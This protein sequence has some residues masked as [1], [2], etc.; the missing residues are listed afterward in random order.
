MQGRVVAFENFEDRHVPEWGPLLGL[1]ELRRRPYVC[2]GFVAMGRDPGEGILRRLDDLQ[3]GV[4]YGRSYFS[5]NVLEEP[6]PDY[7]FLYL[8]QDVLNA[9]LAGSI[10]P[11][12]IETLP[13][14]LSA[15]TPFEGLNIVDRERVRCA[16][17]DG[18]EP[19]LLHHI[20]PGKP[21]LQPMPEG[22][23]S[24]L[25]RRTLVGDGLAIEV[26]PEMV[27]TRLRDGA[28]AALARGSAEAWLSARLW[29]GLWRARAK[30]RVAMLRGAGT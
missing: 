13:R 24:R 16:A 11:S 23:Y 22:I 14:R 3:R 5:V 21:W 12:L 17:P 4:D 27:P 26:P 8:D 6:L 10:D 9:I 15:T 25:L 19:Y 28:G 20:L 1:G 30:R 18:T 2:S 7:P 29:A